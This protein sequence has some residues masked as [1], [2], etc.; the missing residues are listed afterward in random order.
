MLTKNITLQNVHAVQRPG[1]GNVYKAT[2]TVGE[3]HGALLD[4]DIGYS[5]KYQ[6]GPKKNV[7]VEEDKTGML[8]SIYD[9]R[10]NIVKSRAEQIAVKYL[11]ARNVEHS[12][13]VL[14]NSDV[15]WNARNDEDR[16]DPDHDELK[17]HLS[18]FSRISIP[19]SA[20]RH[21]GYFLLGLWK[22]DPSR[23]PMQ[24]VVESE[25]GDSVSREQ[26]QSWLEEF[27]PFDAKESSV[28][29]EIYNLTQ[30]AEGRLFSEFNELNQ[31]PSNAASIDM[32][33]GRTPSTRF[34]DS[35]MN[36]SAVFARSEIETR[37]NTIG[38][39]SRKLTTNA[40]MAS[41]IKPFSKRLFELEKTP[42][43]YEDLIKFF[44]EFYDDWSNHHKEFLPEASAD[45]RNKLRET[46]FALSNIIFFPMFRLA[47]ELWEKYRKDGTNW[48]AS[49][50]WRDGL[51]RLAGVTKVTV[52]DV[53]VEVP[54]LA[55]DHKVY[56]NKDD[57]EG[58]VVPGNP[59][60]RGKILVE[61]FDHAGKPTGWSVSST[62]QT[63]DA[64]FHYL[65]EMSKM[66]L[67]PR[68]SA[69]TPRSAGKS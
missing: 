20:H 2:V 31:K 6:R 53:K 7:E 18:I 39:K 23:I 1:I 10:L 69:K 40:T 30:E 38:S 34:V 22:K 68:S 46:S 14:Y 45:A 52:G 44:V 51:A 28:F 9:N 16:P 66:K 54:V 24:V 11:M 58:S 32:Y 61:T 8:L 67:T 49:Q 60:W 13:Y 17:N 41:A 65:V 62:R 12:P 27:D 48:N 4:G 5:L 56:K 37:F 42:K 50:E 43:A 47:F 36:A 21:Y 63:R 3:L 15:I 25:S 29:V 26:I 35:L 57:K 19:D 55:R 59:D 33:A 64:A